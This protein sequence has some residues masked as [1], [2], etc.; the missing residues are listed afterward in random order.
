MFSLISLRSGQRLHVWLIVNTVLTSSHSAARLTY[1]DMSTRYDSV[2]VLTETR[3]PGMTVLLSSQRSTR[4]PGMTML[5]YLQRHVRQVWQCCCP[6][7]DTS[8]RYDNVVVLTET[9]PPGMTVLLSL[10]RS[11]RPPGMT[12]LLSLQRSTRPPGMTVLFSL[13]RHIHQVWQC[14]CPYRDMSTKYDSVIF[15]TEYL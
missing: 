14:Y 9:R 10:Q 11:T 7:R 3:P 1:R 4:P 13:Q 15:F 5:L 6:Y 2:I 8:T 12:V